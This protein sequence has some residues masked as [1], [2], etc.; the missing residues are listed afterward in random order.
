MTVVKIEVVQVQG[1]IEWRCFRAR[2]GNWVAVCDPLALTVQSE[3]YAALMEDIAETINAMLHDLVASSELD[4]FLRERGW[5]PTGPI[6]PQPEGVWFDVPFV[7]RTA[8]RDREAVL[9]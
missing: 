2:G 8:D 5:R 3:T 9:R 4:R 7:T 6:P 1:N